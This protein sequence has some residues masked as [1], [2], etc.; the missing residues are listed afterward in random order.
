MCGRAPTSHEAGLRVPGD[1]AVAGFDDIED[2]R[3]SIP[4]LTTVAP[5]KERIAR[6]AVELLANRLDG[7]QAA[8]AR[9]L[10]APYRLEQ[11]ESTHP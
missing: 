9:E 6:L 10:S 2:G 7:D 11:R 5:D 8:P 1:V 4:T 3:F